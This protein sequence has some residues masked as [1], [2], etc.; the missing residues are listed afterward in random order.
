MPSLIQTL[1][2]AYIKHVQPHRARIL[3]IIVRLLIIA[4]ISLFLELVVFNFRSI[5]TAFNQPIDLSDKIELQQTGDGRYVVSSIQNTIE[6]KDVN[7]TIENIHFK[8][9]KN[10]GGQEFSLKINF[11]DSGHST[12]FNSTEYSLGVP[13]VMIS[14]S[15]PRSQYFTLHTTGQV[16]DIKFQIG[17]KD[18][19]YPLYIDSIIINDKYPFE[20]VLWRFFVSFL[21]LY[22]I[23][24]FR[25]R[26]SVY[27]IKLIERPLY[28]K[29]VICCTIAFEAILLCGYLSMGPN[30]VGL[31]TANYN[32]SE[33]DGVS[34]VNT[35]EAA[36]DNAQQYAELAKSFTKGKLYL[37]QEPPEYLKT[38][39]DP[40][41]KGSRD[42]MQKSTG[43]R[44][45]F[46]VAYYNGHY[47][48]YFGVVPVL[49]FYLPFYLLTGANFPTA[50][51][52]LIM[53][54]LFI[55]GFSVLLD[56]FARYHFER[57][58]LGLYL[59]LQ[60]P[61]VFC[62]GV[63]YLIKFPTFYS[64]PIACAMAFAVW[65]LYFWMRARASKRPHGWFIA[66]SLCMALIAGCRPQIMLIAFVAIPLFWRKFIKNSKTEGLRCK[67]GWGHFACLAMPFVIVGI[68]LMWYNYARFGSVSN[69]GANYNL[70]MNDMTQR[71][72]QFA[73]ILPAL[74]TYFIQPPNVSGVFPFI[75]P[76]VFQTTY[77]GQTIK[78]VTFGG[79]FA[80]LP[81][82]WILFFSPPI[83]RM[84]TRIRKTQTITGVIV[85]L[86]LS[87]VLIAVLDAQVAGLL[88]R[89]YADFSFMLLL[90]AVL[91]AFIVNEKVSLM[92][93]KYKNI[94]V[95]IM[96]AAVGISVLY[97]ALTC[98]VVETG[99]YGDVFR[100]DYREF[101]KSALFWT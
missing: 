56:R 21:I 41:D 67:K 30:L 34:L 65:A 58:S 78:E 49:L 55:I 4:A 35:F 1:K 29:V 54:I 5:T 66:G 15:A 62:C 2:Y 9:N 63:L 26:S 91:L 92:P 3:H 42:E 47:Y 98:F 43:E 24:A 38:M 87:A 81:V 7:H 85:V 99:W 101:L 70:T 12:Y 74:F 88:Q 79:V 71:G 59:L 50:V 18:I 16:K 52:V 44:Y 61:M 86:I 28:S 83:L 13:E 14:T 68:G 95:G 36:G 57:V 37:E 11:T 80:C 23:Y 60:I 64:L 33:W 27:K 32:Y 39:D 100:A 46:D 8:M 25:P 31:A 77:L 20:F 53:A 48:V 76:V 22:L 6:L 93:R 51:G 72:M 17:G 90:A 84:R 75:N 96:L 97:S 94:I 45:L 10:Q 82:L 19:N 73:R 69:F 40:Y 89:Y